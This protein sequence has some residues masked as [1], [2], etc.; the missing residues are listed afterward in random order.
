MDPTRSGGACRH[1]KDGP[2]PKID[3]PDRSSEE[4]GGGHDIFDSMI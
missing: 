4:H 1:Y 2:F 3:C